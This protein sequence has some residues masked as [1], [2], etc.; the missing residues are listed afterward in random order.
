MNKYVLAIGGLLGLAALLFFSQLPEQSRADA[1]GVNDV[2]ADPAAYVGEITITGIMAAVSQED[3]TI[4][5][6]MD[7]AELQ[8]Q[9]E[10]CNKII[11]PIQYGGQTPAM[12]DEV[13]VTGSFSDT[14]KGRLFKASNVQVVR[15]HQLEG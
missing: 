13:L 8:C 4:F 12:G 9:L 1:L 5:G 6:I 3:A 10:N 7:V 14:Q 11:L 15:N 2:G